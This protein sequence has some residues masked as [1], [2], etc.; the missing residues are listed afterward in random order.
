MRHVEK[1]HYDFYD[2]CTFLVIK[3][4]KISTKLL[5]DILSP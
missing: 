4:N 5:K 2:I 3:L 1:L